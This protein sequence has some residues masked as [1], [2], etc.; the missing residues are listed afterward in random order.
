MGPK[1]VAL[2][3][4]IKKILPLFLFPIQVVLSKQLLATGTITHSTLFGLF[5]IL[6]ILILFHAFLLRQ[7][8]KNKRFLFFCLLLYI[9]GYT[10][11]RLIS[12]W[13]ASEFLFYL[14]SAMI[15]PLSLSVAPSSNESFDEKLKRFLGEGADSDMVDSKKRP[16][17]EVGPS[18]DFPVGQNAW[19]ERSAPQ[20][21]FGQQSSTH[22]GIHDG[23][24]S[25][26]HPLPENQ[27]QSEGV[28]EMGRILQAHENIAQLIREF[29]QEEQMRIPGGFQLEHLVEILEERH[30]GNK[31]VSIEQE[32]RQN[33]RESFFYQESK[34]DFDVLRREGITEA[35][36]RREWQGR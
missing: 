36:L 15:G 30:G 7:K 14:L 4:M 10:I 19:A 21:P 35:L 1:L 34:A 27:I 28:E 22:V 23:R 32:M 2:H 9:I 29:R 8:Q 13:F 11:T 20:V 33:R 3:I 12:L 26:A 16:R 25:E 6:L 18:G 31:M 24:S 17:E 5:F